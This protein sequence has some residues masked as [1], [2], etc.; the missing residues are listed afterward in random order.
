MYY[1]GKR[2]YYTLRDATS[3]DITSAIVHLTHPVRCYST[4]MSWDLFLIWYKSLIDRHIDEVIL[5]GH[6]KFRVDI[7]IPSSHNRGR[8]FFD[9]CI[10]RV[11]DS[12]RGIF[13]CIGLSP[14]LVVYESRSISTSKHSSHVIVSNYTITSSD[15][16]KVIA[17]LVHALTYEPYNAYID[18]SIYKSTQNLRIELSSKPGEYRPKMRSILSDT[19]STD[20]RDGIITSMTNTVPVSPTLCMYLRHVP[21]PVTSVSS[22]VIYHANDDYD[23]ISE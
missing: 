22:H 2:F 21:R 3:S 20:I 14:V 11:C 12:I 4:F 16:C 6:Q 19:S 17:Y 10:K 7:D 5:E 23:V 8:S 9:D 18:L 1:H 15:E 13:V